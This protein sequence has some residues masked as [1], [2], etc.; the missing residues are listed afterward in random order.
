LKVRF[1]ETE[2]IERGAEGLAGMLKGENFGKAVLK[3]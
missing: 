3:I 2:G 1:A